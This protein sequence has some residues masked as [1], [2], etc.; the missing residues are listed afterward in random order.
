MGWLTLIGSG[1]EAER[2]AFFQVT[3]LLMLEKPCQD[4]LEDSRMICEG[5]KNKGRKKLMTRVF[6]K[7]EKSPTE[8]SNFKD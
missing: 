2:I 8:G 3:L 7:N 5:Y 4:G 6:V 1:A